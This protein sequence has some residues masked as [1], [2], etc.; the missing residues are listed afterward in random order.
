MYAP[1]VEYQTEAEYRTH[2]ERVYCTGPIETFDGIRVRFRKGRFQHDF[3][4]SSRRDGNKDRFSGDRARRM[5]W[6]L[7]VLKDPS[8]ELYQGWDKKRKKYDPDSRVALV[9]NEYVVVIRLMGPDSAEFVTAYVAG[10]QPTGGQRKSTV[11]MIR[12]GPEWKKMNR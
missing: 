6:I 11:D 12:S 9:V 4:E 5:D 10:A 7:K 1:F 3:Y 8:A 2:F